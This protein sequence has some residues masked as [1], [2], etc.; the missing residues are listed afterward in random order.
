MADISNY[1]R[2]K[3]MSVEEI[4]H[5]IAHNYRCRKCAYHNKCCNGEC[6]NGIKEWL[7]SEVDDG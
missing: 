7:N 5:L 1:E 4:A 6:E 2:I 3:N